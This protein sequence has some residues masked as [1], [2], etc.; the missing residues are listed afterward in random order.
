M[1][2]VTISTIGDYLEVIK[3]HSEEKRRNGT[4]KDVVFRGQGADLPLTPKLCRL[5]AKAD[6]LSVERMI[7]QEFKRSNPLL[8]QPHGA[9]DDWDYLTLGQ[10]FGL[11]T[12]LVDWSDNALTALWFAVSA[13]MADCAQPPDYALVWMLLAGEEDFVLNLEDIHPF[14]VPATKLFRPRLIKQR[15]N[16][17]S[18][19]FTIT[20]SDDIVHKRYMNESHCYSEK[21][22]KLKIPSRNI[23]GLRNDLNTLGVNAF[24]IFPELEGLCAFLQWKF[25]D[26]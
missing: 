11:P 6:L 4:L 18:G 10:H 16:N 24:S 14:E 7:L 19:L 21:L 13:H 15:I 2:E 3:Q 25:F 22:I 17:Q 9:L 12:R 8:I 5:S 20:S 23:P 1:K 26:Q